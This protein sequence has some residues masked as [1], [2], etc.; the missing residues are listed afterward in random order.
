MVRFR[1]FFKTFISRPTRTQ[2][3]L[4]AAGTAQVAHAL[5]AVPFS[6]LLRGRGTSCQDGVVAEEGFLCALF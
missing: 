1:K 3:T 6:C 4:S 5:L 2:H